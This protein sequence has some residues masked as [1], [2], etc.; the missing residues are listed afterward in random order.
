[1]QTNRM[2]LELN[3]PNF[4]TLSDSVWAV[5]SMKNRLGLF[6]L[7]NPE[8]SNIVLVRPLQKRKARGYA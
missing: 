6:P 1:M 7:A 5:F 8:K 2:A 3:S 4:H